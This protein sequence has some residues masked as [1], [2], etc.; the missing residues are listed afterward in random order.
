MD[1]HGS[2]K[3]KRRAAC[4]EGPLSGKV[5]ATFH[6]PA[7]LLEEARDAVVA[8]Y[9][10]VGRL[11]LAELATQAIQAEIERLRKEHNGGEPFPRRASAL[12]TGRPIT[13]RIVSSTSEPMPEQAP[14]ADTESP[15]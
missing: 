1:S 10:P 6:I 15:Q 14:L 7:A 3:R 9:G 8:L 11:T 13:P 12:R 2:R 4:Y 5:R